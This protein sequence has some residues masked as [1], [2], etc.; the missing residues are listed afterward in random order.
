MIHNISKNWMQGTYGFWVMVDLGFSRF[1]FSCKNYQ[2]SDYASITKGVGFFTTN[3]TKLSL[4]FSK[5]STIFYT[6]YKILQNSSTIWDS[7]LPQGPWKGSGSYKYTLT[8]RVSPQKELR[9]RNVVLG[10]AAGAGG[11][12]PASSGGGVGQGRAWGGPGVP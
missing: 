6:I 9:S 1:Y 11:E 4:H 2:E 5:F 3:P 12:I 10:A 8:L 7:L